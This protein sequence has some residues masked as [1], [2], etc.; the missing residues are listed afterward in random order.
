[1]ALNRVT[2][3]GADDSTDP[4]ELQALSKE[5]PFVEWAILVGSHARNRFPSNDWIGKLIECRF[6][7]NSEMN[8]S[9]HLCGKPLR[10]VAIGRSMLAGVLGSKLYAF[11]RVQLNWHGERQH[12][13]VGENVF[14]AFCKLDIG[15]WDPELIFQLDGVNDNL[16]KPSA[17][18][19][20]CTGLFDRSHGAGVL[21]GEWPEALIDIGC[22]WAGGLGPQNLAEEIPKIAAK[23]SPLRDYW[24][25]METHVRSE[26]DSVLDMAK[27]RQCLEIS[28]QFVGK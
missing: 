11:R 12:S 19:F 21:P 22:G 26:D 6:D 13:Y 8:L 24:I 5:F 14:D 2:I 10:D 4:K 9:L 16:W 20:A 7:A 1:M 3:T 27:V 28:Q 18:R 15:G 25:D 23:V 17:R